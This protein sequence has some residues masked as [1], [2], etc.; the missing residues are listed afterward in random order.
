MDIAVLLILALPLLVIA[1][2]AVA[3]SMATAQ[4]DSTLAA[5]VASARRHAVV[6]SVLAGVAM[7][8]AVVLALGVAGLTGVGIAPRV[9]ACLPLAATAVALVVLLLGELTWPRPHGATRTAV[10]H[11]R[12]AATD[13]PPGRSWTA[14]SC[15]C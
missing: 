15:A 11:D 1:A 12:S 5:E 7:T 9:L 14:G 8:V 4:P 13:R 3:L 10:L 2:A 6:T